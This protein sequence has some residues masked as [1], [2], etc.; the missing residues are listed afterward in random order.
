MNPDLSDHSTFDKFWRGLEV[1]TT[2]SVQ[3]SDRDDLQPGLAVIKPGIPG[4]RPSEVH[5]MVEGHRLRL[6]WEHGLLARGP[7]MPPARER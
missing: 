7:E 1:R 2:C 6:T 4:E 5:F 3:N